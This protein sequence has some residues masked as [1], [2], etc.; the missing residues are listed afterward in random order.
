MALVHEELYFSPDLASIDFRSYVNELLTGQDLNTSDRQSIEFTNNVVGICLPI[1][2]AVPCGL[3][4]NELVTN[5][6]QHAFPAGWEGERRLTIAMENKGG[7]NLLV[8]ADTGVGFPP[9]FDP[10]TAETLGMQLA[11]TAIRQLHGTLT[12]EPGPGARFRIEFPDGPGP[13]G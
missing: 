13:E 2:S 5:A 10:A 8:V 7:N 9:D 3:A 6:I 12:V 11:C 1:E 4:L